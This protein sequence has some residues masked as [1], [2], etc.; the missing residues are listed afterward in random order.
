M[1]PTAY[2]RSTGGLGA[3]NKEA[4]VKLDKRVDDNWEER[5]KLEVLYQNRKKEE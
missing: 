3:L 5:R 4:Q 2:L 1:Q